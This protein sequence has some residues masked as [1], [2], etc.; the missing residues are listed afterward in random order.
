MG[1]SDDHKDKRNKT[2]PVVWLKKVFGS[3]DDFD[4][5][6]EAGEI[7][8]SDQDLQASRFM[9]KSLSKLNTF[10]D[11]LDRLGGIFNDPYAPKA[12]LETSDGSGVVETDVGIFHPRYFYQ[13]VK[14]ETYRAE[15]FKLPFSLMMID[16]VLSS[17][18]TEE[19]R[20]VA[21]S[22]VTL[23]V[24]KLCREVDILSI[25]ESGEVVL[26]LPNTASSG[27]QVLVDRVIKHWG[28]LNER[29]I[30]ISAVQ[31]RSRG[32]FNWET[33]IE[34][35]REILEEARAS[36]QPFICK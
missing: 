30:V 10:D 1:S 4:G 17:S 8:G 34:Y 31:Y 19:E 33:M 15:R 5:E 27:T 14:Q 21:A 20:R 3:A 28:A 32:D 18:M 23:E 25:L 13:L 36:G 26:L 22:L 35:T 7:A 2:G 6:S 11:L 12:P 9:E 16:F 29:S 24:S